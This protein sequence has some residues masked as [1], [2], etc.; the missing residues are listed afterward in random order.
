MKNIH[1]SNTPPKNEDTGYNI[2]P[3]KT[4]EMLINDAGYVRAYFISEL[5]S[6]QRREYRKYWNFVHKY[7]KEKKPSNVTYE[8]Y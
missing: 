6:R 8:D 2:P 7:V 5:Y 1:W 3:I 4:A